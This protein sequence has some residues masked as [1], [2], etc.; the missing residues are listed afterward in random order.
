M[1]ALKP[2]EQVI[3]NGLQQVRPGVT[4]EPKLVEMPV[5]FASRG[6]LTAPG[7]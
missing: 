6:R 5:A 4:V 7:W 3:V 2:G 1:D